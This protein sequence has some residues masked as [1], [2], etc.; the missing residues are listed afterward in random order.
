MAEA[1]RSNR[2][3]IQSSLFQGM[4]ASPRKSG[5]R[6]ATPRTPVSGMRETDEDE[7]E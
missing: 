2:E 5:T 1:P 7:E 6:P 3:P 4:D